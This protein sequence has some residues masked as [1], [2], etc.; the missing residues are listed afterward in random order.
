VVHSDLKPENV[1]VFFNNGSLLYEAKVADL[2]FSSLSVTD[3]DTTI[4]RMP[5]TPPWHAPEWHHRFSTTEMTAAKKMDV[6]SY[7][8]L[9]AWIL[10]Y[11]T[12]MNPKAYFHD[13]FDPECEIP[14]PVGKYIARC[15]DT[16][17]LDRSRLKELFETSLARDPAQRTS[18]MADLIS[19]LS[20]ERYGGR[21]SL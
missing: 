8:L 17:R 9:C 16:T 4:I 13:E 1:L 3:A 6:Y 15:P 18:S 2:G 14:L 19:L 7:G 20:P 11:N 12:S 21:L 10:F 5:G